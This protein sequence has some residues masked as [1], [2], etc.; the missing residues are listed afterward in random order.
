MSGLLVPKGLV[1]GFQMVNHHLDG[2]G[3]DTVAELGDAS[4]LQS[5]II[6]EY[7]DT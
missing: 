4:L 1:P 3:L 6:G 5:E 7:S 2:R